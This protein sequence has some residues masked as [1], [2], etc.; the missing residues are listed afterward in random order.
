VRRN[1]AQDG[2]ARRFELPTL[3]GSQRPGGDGD[4]I[5][6][7]AWAFLRGRVAIPAGGRRRR[8]VRVKG[9]GGVAQLERLGFGNH[10][11]PRHDEQGNDEETPRPSD[12]HLSPP[13]DLACIITYFGV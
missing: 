13:C 4:L 2:R 12:S 10:R 3:V 5:A 7:P 1:V 9:T 8:G 11:A 6:P